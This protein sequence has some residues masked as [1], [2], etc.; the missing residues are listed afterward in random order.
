MAKYKELN[1][2]ILSPLIRLKEISI[3]KYRIKTNSH[4]A[5]T[6]DTPLTKL[7]RVF[8]NK[9]GRVGAHPQAR[10]GHFQHKYEKCICITI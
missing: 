5:P 6:V 2:N 8:A 7:S 9:S 4:Y 3:L 1:E 10:G